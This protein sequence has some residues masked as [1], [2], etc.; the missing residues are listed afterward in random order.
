MSKNLI[1][2]L[3]V[4]LLALTLLALTGCIEIIS[5]V[6]AGAYVT[7]EYVTTGAVSKTISY[8]FDRIKKALLV[9]LCRMQ[10]AVD[11]A[12][13]IENGEEVFATADELEIRIELREITPSVTRISVRARKSYL[14]R[15][16]A[17]AEEILQQTHEIAEKL[18]T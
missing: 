14:N 11:V 1:L 18:S 9:A 12:T 2:T 5:A 7:A 3:K 13:P 15:D 4:F 10:I 17:T 6:G 8:E 16:K